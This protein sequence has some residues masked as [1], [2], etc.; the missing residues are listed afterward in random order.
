MVLG[1]PCSGKKSLARMIS[2]KLRAAF[3][4][5]ENLVEEAEKEQREQ[6]KVFIKKRK[7]YKPIL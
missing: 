1:P 2:S 5:P 6:A 4:T 3:L 7:V